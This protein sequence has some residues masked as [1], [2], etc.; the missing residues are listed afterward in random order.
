MAVRRN[1]SRVVEVGVLHAQ[2]FGFFIH[3]F[4]E[5]SIEPLPMASARVMAASLADWMVVPL[6]KELTLTGTFGSRNMREPSTFP[7]DV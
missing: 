5:L 7:A 6:I 1:T 4:N 3:L 2:A